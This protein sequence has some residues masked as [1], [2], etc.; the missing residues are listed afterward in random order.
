MT[1]L[2][3]TGLALPAIGTA[4]IADLPVETQLPT[5]CMLPALTPI[6]IEISDPLNSKT[7]KIGDFFRIRLV[8][9]IMVNN[10]VIVPAGMSG[11]GEVIHAA[12]AR[13]AG[14]PGELIIAARWI[15]FQGKKLPLR[16]FKYGSSAGK[17]NVDTAAAA[18]IIIAA[19][20]MLF[21]VGGQV[22]I[23]VGTRAQ[24]KLA[25]DVFISNPQPQT[26]MI[27]GETK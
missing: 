4:Q 5:C 7:S 24:A 13:V 8:Q 2:I 17:S 20:V 18:G 11:Q 22:N 27:K 26:I 19:P 14:K 6:E 23:P 12:K 10:T 15:D 1:L 21:I 3:V 9:P 25:T 16:S